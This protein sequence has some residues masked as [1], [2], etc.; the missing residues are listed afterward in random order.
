VP[1]FDVAVVWHPRRDS[2]RAVSFVRDEI[3]RLAQD[4]AGE[5]AGHSAAS[6]PARARRAKRR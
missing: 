6:R 3:V 2:D 5:G 4:I 1:G